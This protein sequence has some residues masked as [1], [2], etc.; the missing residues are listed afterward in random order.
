MV[1]DDERLRHVA[2]HPIAEHLD[3]VLA[4][5]PNGEHE[6]VAAEPGRDEVG[7]AD[8]VDPVGDRAEHG[9]AGRLAVELVDRTEVDDVDDED[10][11]A[12][13]ELR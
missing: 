6:L 11:E 12:A 13:T 10:A 5:R 8:L 1:A 7:P 9:V 2:P 4:R 3:R